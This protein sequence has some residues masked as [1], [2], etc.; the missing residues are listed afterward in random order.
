MGFSSARV[1]EAF[2]RAAARWASTR[3]EEYRFYR[4]AY[5]VQDLDSLKGAFGSGEVL[6]ACCV[7]RKHATVEDAFVALRRRGYGGDFVRA[8]VLSADGSKRRQAKREEPLGTD[9][10]IVKV[11]TNRKQPWQASLR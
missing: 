7:L 3:V 6:G 8:D 1:D 11:A 9:T 4:Y 2:T 5:P 10:Q